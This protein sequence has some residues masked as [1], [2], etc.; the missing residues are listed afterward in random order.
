[1]G[2]GKQQTLIGTQ[3]SIL[4]NVTR[5]IGDALFQRLP[6]EQSRVLQQFEVGQIA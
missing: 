4:R 3:N 6:A 2:A 5:F 1:M